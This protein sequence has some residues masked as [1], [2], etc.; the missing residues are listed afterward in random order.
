M[1]TVQLIEFIIVPITLAV[2]YFIAGHF[3]FFNPDSKRGVELTKESLKETEE[4]KEG[5]PK[6]K[7][8][9]EEL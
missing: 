9:H 8:K 2:I 6:E 5:T 7:G 1:T 4:A 3:G